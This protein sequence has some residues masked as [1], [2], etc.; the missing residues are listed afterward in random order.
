[1]LKRSLGDILGTWRSGD[2][3]DELSFEVSEGESEDVIFLRAA[4]RR[5]DC[6]SWRRAS[7]AA[8]R[9]WMWRSSD[10]WRVEF[11]WS[12]LLDCVEGVGVVCV[13]LRKLVMSRLDLGRIGLDFHWVVSVIVAINIEWMG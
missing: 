7:S 3:D 12:C 10:F 9:C 2:E 13:P 11:V 5:E 8:T 6:S 4:S 1:M